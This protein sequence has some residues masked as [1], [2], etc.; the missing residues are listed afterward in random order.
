MALILKMFL[1]MLILPSQARIQAQKN[2]AY[3][4]IQAQA[5]ALTQAQAEDLAQ[6][7]DQRQS[8]PTRW[9]KKTGRKYPHIIFILS[10]DL[11]WDDIGIHGSTQPKTPHIYALIQDSVQMQNYYTQSSCNPARASLQLGG[12]SFTR[13]PTKLL[14]ISARV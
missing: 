14:L 1:L 13:V 5:R 7:R 11:G 10:D 8:Q 3:A 4:P 6:A 2:Q 9:A 12:T